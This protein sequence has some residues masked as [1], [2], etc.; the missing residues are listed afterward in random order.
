M[1]KRRLFLKL[2]ALTSASAMLT[3]YVTSGNN[4]PSP[5]VDPR[6][7]VLFNMVHHNPGEPLF[8]TQYTEPEYL[9]ERAYK[10]Q[11]TKNYVQ[12]GL[13]Y[14]DWEE[15]I[16]AEKTE[17]KLWI[18]RHAA[19]IRVQINSAVTAG[20]PVYPFTDILVLPKSVMDKYGE[21][22]SKDGKITILKEKTK[23]I[24]RA[25]IA[26]IFTRF[27]E[28]SG[29]TIRHG[30]TYLMDTP[31]HKGSSPARTEEEH[32]ILINILKEEICVKRNKKLFYRTWDFGYFHTQPDFYL[33][34]TKG[35]EPHP[36][37]FFS[38]KHTNGD[39]LRGYPFNKTIG[40]GVHQQIVEI[41][42]NQAGCYGK[43]AHPYYIGK[44]VI[45]GWSEMEDKKG[46]RN[47]FN[48]SKIKGFWIW[49]WGDGW[50]GPYFDNELWINLNEYVLREYA[51]NPMET[52]ENLFKKYA[53][54]HLN[55]TKE[56]SN[57]LREL[58]LLSTDAVY[59]GQASK[60]INVNSF[61]C[62]DHYIT[63]VNLEKAVSNNFVEKIL[64]EKRI[65]MAIFYRMEKLAYQ[66][67]M[68]KQSDEEFL[69][70]STTYGRIKYEIIALV[71][72]IQMILEEIKAGK[73]LD[74]IEMKNTLKKYQDK[75]AEWVL[76]KK[77][78]PCCPTIY[79]DHIAVYCG[80]PFQTSIDQLQKLINANAG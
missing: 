44:G 25:Q 52:E 73:K 11:V 55:L 38:I 79:L 36:L 19:S 80:P 74:I 71:W 67:K 51:L 41:S 58:C 61:W 48:D 24:V 78:Y 20:M 6:Y 68:P 13:T 45:E 60:Y 77:K 43:N 35:V 47:L 39:F 56:D 59:Y 17:E 40:I 33:A 64:D 42:I 30:E 23:E 22:I 1:I 50:A 2:S 34:A 65:N 76:L 8:T 46:I 53:L 14:D 54:E 57:K 5:E 62:R 7:T 75:W 28:L 3:P 12:C 18:E 63:S 49:T 70:I 37:L 9:K 16:I 21:A 26:E 4:K 27:P 15:N 10:G 29:L 32:S 66:I 31:F 72:L 69:R